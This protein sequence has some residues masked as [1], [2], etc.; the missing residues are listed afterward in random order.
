[1]GATDIPQTFNVT[2]LA[3]TPNACPQSILGSKA[4]GEPPLQLASAAFF[5]LKDAIRAVPFASV[6]V[7][8]V[9]FAFVILTCVRVAADGRLARRSAIPTT[10]RSTRR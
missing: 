4:T 8:S 1:L 3:N 2:L 7:L 5:A 10:S 6:L 9:R